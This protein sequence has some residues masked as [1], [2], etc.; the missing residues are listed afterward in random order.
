MRGTRLSPSL[1][2]WAELNRQLREIVREKD[3]EALLARL[4]EKDASPRWL[5]RTFA[6]LKRLRQQRERREFEAG[7][8]AEYRGPRTKKGG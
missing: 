1:P 5:R 3:V 7:L 8:R 4:R 6:R 2:T